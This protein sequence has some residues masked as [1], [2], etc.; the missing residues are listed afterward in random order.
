MGGGFD[1][2]GCVLAEFGRRGVREVAFGPAFGV[3]R[4]V[5]Q[6][7]SVIPG[8][9]IPES[10]NRKL[11]YDGESNHAPSV[12]ADSQVFHA[13]I[14]VKEISRREQAAGRE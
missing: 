14:V 3:H 11:G 13:I 12:F 9:E 4:D 7:L 1:D 8:G 2:C 6:H 5:E 10:Y